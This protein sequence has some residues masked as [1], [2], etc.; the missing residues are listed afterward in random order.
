[1]KLEQTINRSQKSSGGVGQAKADS[2]VT[3]WELVDHELKPKARTGPFLHNELGGNTSCNL[4]E[5]V[6][7]VVKFIIEERGN[8]YELTT[9]PKLH[10]FTSGQV[11]SEESTAKLLKYFEHGQEKYEK[12]R[13]DRY[14][15]KT[16]K[17]SDTITKVNLPK[18]EQKKQKPKTNQQ[19]V[20]S[21]AKRI[22]EAQKTD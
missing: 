12:F 8:P 15:T 13:N 4:K 22:G 3:E 5:A 18:F 11:V 6:T 20:N 1:M 2:Y 17:F 14:V 10:N 21:T 19:L 16:K 9:N 7:K